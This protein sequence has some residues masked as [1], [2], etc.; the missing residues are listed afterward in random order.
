MKID[1]YHTKFESIDKS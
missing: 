1:T